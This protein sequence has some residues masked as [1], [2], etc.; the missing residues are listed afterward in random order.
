MVSLFLDGFKAWPGAQW[1]ANLINTVVIVAFAI[2]L[3]HMEYLRNRIQS[4]VLLFYWLLVLVSDSIKLRTVLLTG[5]MDTSEI[6]YGISYLLSVVIFTLENVKRP[7]N[8]DIS[9]DNDESKY[10]AEENSSIFSRLFFVWMT[11]LIQKGYQ[12]PLTRDDLWPLRQ[13]DYSHILSKQF[14][15]DW[16]RELQRGRPSLARALARVCGWKFVIAG[17]IKLMKDLLQ[18]AQPLLLKQLILWVGSYMTDHPQRPEVGI[19]ISAGMFLSSA[20]STVCLHQYFQIC[21]ST[22]MKVRAVLVTSIYRKTLVLSNESRQGSTVG[23]IVNHMAVDTTRIMDLFPN[24]HHVWGAPLQ[25]FV[26]LFLLHQIMGSSIWA[27]VFVLVLAVPINIVIGKTM[28][29]YQKSQMANKDMRIKTMNEILNGIKVIKLY[30]WEK[31]FM[32]KIGYIR[33][34]LELATL[35]K[36]G[37]ISALQSFTWSSVPFLVTVA[38]FAVYISTSQPLTSDIVF[39]A[40]SLFSMLQFPLAMGPDLISGII[41]ASVS[42]TRIESYL[43]L[44]EMDQQAITHEDYRELSDWTLQTPLVEIQHGAFQ[45]ASQSTELSN[46]AIEEGLETQSSP[47]SVLN[48][49]NIQVKKGE[50][51]AVVGRVGAGKSSLISALLG[52]ITKTNGMVTLRG[53]TAYAPQQPW[54]LNATVRENITFGHRFDPVFYDKVLDACSLRTD[55]LILTDGDQTEIGERGINLSGGQKARISLARA[56]YSRADIYLLDDP[57]SAVDAHV[58]KHLFDKVIGPNGLLKNKSRILVTHAISHLPLVDQIVMIRDK[59]IILNDTY[60]VLMTNKTELYTLLMEYSNSQSTNDDMHKSDSDDDNISS[61]SSI[62]SSSS[63]SLRRASRNELDWKMAPTNHILDKATDD[64]GTAMGNLMTSEEGAKGSVDFEVYKTYIAAASWWAMGATVILQAISQ[65]LQV[66]ANVWLKEWSANNDSGVDH[67]VWLYLSVYALIG[68]S[69]T[70]FAVTQ[71]IVLR[72]YCAI[73]SAKILHFRMLDAVMHS[74]MS[75]FDTTPMG[76]ILNRFAKDQHTVDELIP[77]VFGIFFRVFPVVIATMMVIGFS[78][79]LFLVFMV[80]LF[81]FY[82]N[83]QKQYLAASRELKRLDSIGRSPIYSHFQE[84]ITGVSTIRAYEQQERFIYQNEWKLDSNQQAYYAS[85][86]SNRW[87]SV[88]LELLGS[89][90]IFLAAFLSVVGVLYQTASST[91]FMDDPISTNSTAAKLA[92]AMN[93]T[94]DPGLVGLS[95]S[96]ALSVTSALTFLIRSYC[97][98]ETRIVSVERIKEYSELPSEKYKGDEC[99]ANDWPTNG[100]ISF[101]DFATRYRPGLSLC[102]QNISFTVRP[103]EKIG[104]CGRTGSGKSSLTLS[105][106]R[107]LEA[108][109]GSIVIDG[110]PIHRLGLTELRSRLSIIPQ[111]PVLFVGSVRENLDPL[112]KLDDSILWTALKNSHLRDVIEAMDGKLDATVLEGGENFSVGQR[113]LICLAR[114]LLRP[115]CILVLDEA[116]AAIDVE[117]DAL[118]QDTIRHHFKHCTVLTIAHR[119]KSILDSDKILLVDQGTVGEFDTP[120]SLLEDKNS[121]FYSLCKEANV[122]PL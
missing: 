112:G 16:K 99:P 103:R 67:N 34:D 30:A 119:V 38:T 53:S 25:V 35:K 6:L 117:T 81:L 5:T 77:R 29:R 93:V 94:V 120:A 21:F 97:E 69:S 47:T 43:A 45:W 27:G 79:P 36:I 64:D 111:E 56:V 118:I 86:S 54:L 61:A 28:R 14:E 59:T 55:L 110:I 3:H 109:E 33:N 80:P 98:V 50:L 65:A 82:R 89:F 85:M 102:L 63:R 78:T 87:L 49:I 74:P 100:Q 75:F 22:S 51:L 57:L 15:Q 71:T 91:T 121:K 1:I 114:A 113:Q 2:C 31:P 40:I 76:R 32:D 58:G 12:K 20:I 46:S 83:I 116:T 95:V 48:D 8:Q 18:Y 122:V 108:A 90:V 101:F 115:T 41:E 84:T 7:V 106:F 24:L 72:V 92:R 23:E 11:P 4:S 52:D 13:D 26:G 62:K 39:V 96:Y 73:R 10:N 17:I 19:L 70:L 42:L 104:I 37:K 66:G 68:W 44:E 107:I 60:D 9:L 105:L 88:R